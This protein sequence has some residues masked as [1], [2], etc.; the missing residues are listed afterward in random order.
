MD[1]VSPPLLVSHRGVKNNGSYI[2][3]VSSL[4]HTYVS[5]LFF[6]FYYIRIFPVRECEKAAHYYAT[7]TKVSLFSFDGSFYV[8]RFK[9]T[10]SFL[11]CI[12]WL[13][14][15]NIAP[16]FDFDFS[17]DLGYFSSSRGGI[18]PQHLRIIYILLCRL[19]TWG[20]RWVI[21]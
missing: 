6:D 16:K 17:L 4:L 14:F 21:T 11:R 15:K 20:R 8:F 3:C 2:P 18:P 12:V 9:A 13:E 1:G 5:F 19:I 10:T 7:L